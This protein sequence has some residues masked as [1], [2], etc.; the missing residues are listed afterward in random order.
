MAGLTIKVIIKNPFNVSTEEDFSKYN[1]YLGIEK[2]IF[3]PN[4]LNI[5]TASMSW[6]L[7]RIKFEYNVY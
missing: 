7:K 6:I 1:E 3:A 4:N 5:L 2:N